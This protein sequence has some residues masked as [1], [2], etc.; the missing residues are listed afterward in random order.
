[1]TTIVH[2]MTDGCFAPMEVTAEQARA[3]RHYCPQHAVLR[4]QTWLPADAVRLT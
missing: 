4:D 3:G 1:M 2:C